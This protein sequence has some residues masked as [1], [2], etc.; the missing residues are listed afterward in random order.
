[1]KFQR[2]LH[3][4][5]FHFQYLSQEWKLCIDLLASSVVLVVNPE[6]T[7]PSVSKLSKP[8]E[9]G[10]RKQ[11]CYWKYQSGKVL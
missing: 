2:P 9:K 11:G 7:T 4:R 10:T 8:L 1:M 6:G 3:C 5:N